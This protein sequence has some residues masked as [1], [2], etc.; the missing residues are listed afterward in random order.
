M[1]KINLG[2]TEIQVTI[3]GL[4]HCDFGT[5]VGKEAAFKVL[6]AYVEEGGN[7][8]DTSN[9]YA[10]WN[11]G[12]KGGE[13]E[14]VIGEWMKS[15]G[16]RDRIVLATKVGANIEDLD[17][18][19]KPD[20]TL[21]DDWY[22]HGEG[23]SKKAVQKAI[24]GSLRRLQTDYV[25]LYYAHVEDPSVDPAET[26]ETFDGLV[27]QGK[28]RSIGCSNHTSWRIERARQISRQRGLAEYC[29]TQDLH[30]YLSPLPSRRLHFANP[31]KMDYLK[32]NPDMTLI[33]Y[34]PT[35]WGKYAKM[36][37]EK[38]AEFWGEFY[39]IETERKLKA[40]TRVAQA[41]NTSEISIVYAWL[42]R[43]T[44]SAIPLIAT[45]SVEHLR[46]NMA[47][48]E[49]VLSKDEMDLLNNPVD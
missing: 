38:G 30:S 26:L 20:G 5:K 18:V 31:D 2:N 6:D 28:I 34:T 24:E 29:C 39:T 19:R 49:I 4:G 32:N 12:G 46:E 17:K 36:H 35:I 14:T 7:F 11:P 41:H 27:K 45:S 8:I 22:L 33:A 15:R 40:L 48:A 42:I 43:N 16:N 47:A 1:K 3:M 25:D 10:I 23:L 21:V 9:N 44:P 37:T 13:C